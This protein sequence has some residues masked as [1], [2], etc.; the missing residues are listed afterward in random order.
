MNTM[1]AEMSLITWSHRTL[2]TL[3]ACND[4]VQIN[5]F[6]IETSKNT[7]AFMEGVR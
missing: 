1:P 2:P 5:H 3:R 7:C 6:I 4:Q